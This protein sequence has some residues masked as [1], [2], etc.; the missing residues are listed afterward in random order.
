MCNPG[1]DSRAPLYLMGARYSGP[2]VPFPEDGIPIELLQ[3]SNWKLEQ[4]F[5][6]LESFQQL[7]SLFGYEADRKAFC[8]VCTISAQDADKVWTMWG[9]A[10]R[11]TV[12]MLEVFCAAVLSCNDTVKAKTRALFHFFDYGETGKLRRVDFRQ[13]YKN[14]MFGFFRLTA[15]KPPFDEIS[16]YRLADHTWDFG[17]DRSLRDGPTRI[18]SKGFTQWVKETNTVLKMFIEYNTRDKERYARRLEVKEEKAAEKS[19]PSMMERLIS[20]DIRLNRRGSLMLDPPP[21]GTQTTSLFGKSP[22]GEGKT[23][24]SRAFARLLSGMAAWG[25]A[26]KKAANDGGGGDGSPSGG[27]PTAAGGVAQLWQRV[28]RFY[29]Q[30]MN[31][32]INSFPDDIGYEAL[33]KV[34]RQMVE[35]LGDLYEHY[36]LALLSELDYL[37][38]ETAAK[39]TQRRWDLNREHKK[40]LESRLLGDPSTRLDTLRI[41]SGFLKVISAV[42]P[43]LTVQEVQAA[44]R[45]ITDQFNT[46]ITKDKVD[47]MFEIFEKL[48]TDYDCIVLFGQFINALDQA[49]G[50]S[51]E[52]LN[53]TIL[54]RPYCEFFRKQKHLLYKRCKFSDILCILF[55]QVHRRRMSVILGFVKKVRPLKKNEVKKVKG[56]FGLYDRDGSGTIDRQEMAHI[57]KDL[58]FHSKEAIDEI[59]DEIDTDGSGDIDFG[60][61]VNFYRKLLNRKDSKKG[62]AEIEQRRTIFATF[63][64]KT[65]MDIAHDVGLVDDRTS[66]SKLQREELIDALANTMSIPIPTR[67]KS[68]R[69]KRE[70]LEKELEG[71]PDALVFE[72]LE[73]LSMKTLV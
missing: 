57:Y 58:K 2:R 54:C 13:L 24:G 63:E 65:L 69:K 62:K 46:D 5:S 11:G 31:R 41:Q 30:S 40:K 27:S 33:P 43:M 39:F 25:R 3:F 1:E 34:L 49:D 15:Q 14:T 32:K 45:V 37:P 71:D 26:R 20:G 52:N 67:K 10:E 51:R 72:P 22:K 28:K 35:F 9:G 8:E 6:M 59:F 61:F 18:G 12:S 21:P 56:L 48:D 53:P 70:D 36:V 42:H 55:G 50:V 68:R 60:E 23:G 64:T 19:G 17:I 16:V 47:N 4:C 73:D 66:L 29:N 44:G 38:A 7:Q